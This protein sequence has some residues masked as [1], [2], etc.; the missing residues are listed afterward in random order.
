MHTYQLPLFVI[1]IIDLLMMGITHAR[2]HG[3]KTFTAFGTHQ[4]VTSSDTT[5]DAS[6]ACR[7]S[8]WD[9]F[10]SCTTCKIRGNASTTNRMYNPRHIANLCIVYN[11]RFTN[12]HSPQGDRK[13]QQRKETCALAII[14]RH[15]KTTG[16][17]HAAVMRP[18]NLSSPA[19]LSR[20]LQSSFP[21]DNQAPCQQL[22]AYELLAGS[23][24]NGAQA[25]TETIL[26]Q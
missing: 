19:H 3:N 14:T 10:K 22:Q 2:L 12:S 24:S 11:P 25:P 17:R 6:L 18:Y 21:I 15:K 7:R 23:Y 4:K 9:F 13:P 20:A 8:S 5:N 26:Y 16:C 1:K